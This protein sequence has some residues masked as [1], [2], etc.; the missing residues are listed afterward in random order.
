MAGYNASVLLIIKVSTKF[1]PY[2]CNYVALGAEMYAVF[3][4][5]KIVYVWTR[6]YYGLFFYHSWT[7]RL[8]HKAVWIIPIRFLCKLGLLNKKKYDRLNKDVARSLTD[9]RLSIVILISDATMLA[10]TALIV[11]TIANLISLLISRAS[12]AH[13]DRATFILVMSILI[14]PINYFTLWRKDKYLERFKEFHN[15]SSLRNWT[16]AIISISSVI[17]ALLFILSLHLM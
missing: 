15:S 5:K 16:W 11:C 6:L 9:E 10:F 17:L 7:Q 4:M 2:S 12:L 3:Q 8:I 14:V 13:L 1:F